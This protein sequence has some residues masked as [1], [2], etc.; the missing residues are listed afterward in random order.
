MDGGE[1]FGGCD[2]QHGGSEEKEEKSRKKKK[3]LGW[4]NLTQRHV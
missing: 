1:S 3:P 4:K 2:D